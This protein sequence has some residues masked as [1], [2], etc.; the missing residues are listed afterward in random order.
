MSAAGTRKLIRRTAAGAQ[1]A[2]PISIR[3]T[4]AI[5]IIS[6]STVTRTAQRAVVEGGRRV[7][8]RRRGRPASTGVSSGLGSGAGPSGP[9]PIRLIGRDG[10]GVPGGVAADTSRLRRLGRR[11]RLAGIRGRTAGVGTGARRGRRSA[12]AGRAASVAPGANV[13][14]LL[15]RLDAGGAHRA[16]AL[17]ARAVALGDGRLALGERGVALALGL[18]GARGLGVALADRLLAR[19]QRARELRA[20]GVALGGGLVALAR[21]GLGVLHHAVALGVRDGR[22]RA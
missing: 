4:T 17:A 16:V 14:R 18:L 13:R 22:A 20:G 3:S 19:R 21:D 2:R 5:A 10:S 15:R 11:R 6:S 1:S 9:A 8:E 12:G 7:R